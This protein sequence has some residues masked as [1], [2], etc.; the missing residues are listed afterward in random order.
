[1][2]NLLIKFKKFEIGLNDIKNFYGEDLY[3]IEVDEVVNV[4]V[5]DVIQAI[6]YLLNKTIVIQQLVEWVNIIW[7]TDM[8][9]YKTSEEDSIA[10]VM[11]LLESLD[12]EDVSFSNEDYLKMIDSLKN[13]NE[14]TL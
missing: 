2:T 12:E 14:C 13:N 10:S 5:D 1:M 7:F 3:N 8:F 11:S 6:N 9:E 4:S